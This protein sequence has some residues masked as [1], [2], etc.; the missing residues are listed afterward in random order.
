ML[1][2][3]PA[4]NCF[5]F[6]LPS[7]FFIDSVCEKYDKY[8]EMMGGTFR[9]IKDVINESIQSIDMPGFTYTPTENHT[10][11]NG[12]QE[13]ILTPPNQSLYQILESKTFDVTLRFCDGY[14]NYYCLLE[15]FFVKFMSNRDS[16]AYDKPNADKINRYVDLPVTLLLQNGYPLFTFTMHNCLFTGIESINLTKNQITK[17]FITFKIHFAFSG[18]DCGVDIPNFAGNSIQK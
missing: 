5:T 4:P 10:Q 3:N 6:V 2:P 9:S 15:H 14:F 8:F 11:A 13:T 17:D 1:Q 18:I 7:E 12:I 16:N